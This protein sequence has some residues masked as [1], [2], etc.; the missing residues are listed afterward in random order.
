M[1]SVRAAKVW[2]DRR[3]MASRANDPHLK[4]KQTVR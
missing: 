4:Q 2:V 3:D 1:S